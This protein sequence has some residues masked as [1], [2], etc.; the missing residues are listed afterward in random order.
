MVEIETAQDDG[1]RWFTIQVA[2]NQEFNVKRYIER[3]A[4][5]EHV[6]V[7][8][9]EVLVPTKSVVEVKNGKKIT[10]VRKFYPGYVFV[11]MRLLDAEGKVRQNVA[12]FVRNVQGVINFIGG[13]R[14]VPLKNSEIEGILH[15]VEE[16]K[17]KKVLKVEYKMGECVKITHGPFFNLTGNIDEIDSDRGKLKVS[18]AIFGRFT[19]VELE[20]W[21]VERS[22]G[23]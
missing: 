15:Q 11:R 20:Y 21:Q 5:I 17:G 3:F 22:E 6:E 16:V 23:H 12:S 9:R 19:P 13:E 10:K 2:L 4:K 14:P 18:V 8:I 1:M 7:D